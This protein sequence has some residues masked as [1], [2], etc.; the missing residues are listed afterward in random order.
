MLVR[1]TICENLKAHLKDLSATILLDDILTHDIAKAPFIVIKQKDTAI[2]S[3]TSD[4]WKH[5]MGLE[6]Q[7]IA[8]SK[9]TSDELL[10][11]VLLKLESFRGIKNITNISVEKVQVA[12][13]EAFSISIDFEILYFTPSYRA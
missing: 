5:T 8:T 10:E 3:P 6:A 2:A 11:A 13:S 1:N 7:I 4:S 9:A 12:T